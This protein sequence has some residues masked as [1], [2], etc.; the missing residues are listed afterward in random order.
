MVH[1]NEWPSKAVLIFNISFL[2]PKIQEIKIC[3]KSNQT[4]I[5]LTKTIEKR[6]NTYYHINIEINYIP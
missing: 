5:N 2:G 1:L 3:S 6:I 4:I